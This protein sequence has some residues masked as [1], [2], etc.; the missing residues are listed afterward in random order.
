MTGGRKFNT[1]G[2]IKGTLDAIHRKIPITT[3]IEGGATGADERAAGWAR[4]NGIPV[5]TFPADWEVYGNRAGAVRNARMLRDG[6]PHLVIAFP[7]GT[8]T[9]DMV[10]KSIRAGVKTIRVRPDGTLLRV[11]QTP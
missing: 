2:I 8:G 5:L 10:L 1:W 11:N 6:D 7:G 3:L 4:N 9:G